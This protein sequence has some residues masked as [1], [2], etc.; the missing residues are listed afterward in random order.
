LNHLVYRHYNAR[1]FYCSITISILRWAA[2]HGRED[3]AKKLLN[4]VPIQDIAKSTCEGVMSLAIE[5]GHEVI[6]YA[7]EKG[8]SLNPSPHLGTD[9]RCTM[10]CEVGMLLWLECYS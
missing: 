3:I 7:L 1:Y 8:I 9:S 10:Q 5:Q 4:E 6:L 2:K